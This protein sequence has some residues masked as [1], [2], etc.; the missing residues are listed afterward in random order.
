M[1]LKS[2]AQAKMKSGGLNNTSQA[3]TRGLKYNSSTQVVKSSDKDIIDEIYKQPDP[4]DASIRKRYQAAGRVTDVIPD[5]NSKQGKFF[6][7]LR[8]S[9]QKLVITDQAK[10]ANSKELGL[11]DHEGNLKVDPSEPCL[12]ET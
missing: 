3:A 11:L 9:G 5:R 12:I 7:T 1:A 6:F 8:F 10:W 2:P 4:I